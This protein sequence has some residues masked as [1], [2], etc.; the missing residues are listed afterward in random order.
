MKRQHSLTKAAAAAHRW[1]PLRAGCGTL[2]TTVSAKGPK[3]NA[4]RS[5]RNHAKAD[6]VAFAYLY[7][8]LISRSGGTGHFARGGTSFATLS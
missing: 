1:A 3:N 6:A 7:A 4:A 8:I 5:E 2:C